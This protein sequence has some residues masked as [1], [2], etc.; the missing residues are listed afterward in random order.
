[1]ASPVEEDLLDKISAIVTL[2][3]PFLPLSLGGLGWLNKS[4][5][6]ALQTRVKSKNVRIH[7]FEDKL[8]EDRI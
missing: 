7:K 4:N 6:Q 5:I 2:I 1:M 3:T 8:R